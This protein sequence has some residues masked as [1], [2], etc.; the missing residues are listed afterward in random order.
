MTYAPLTDQLINSI[1][2]IDSPYEKPKNSDIHIKSDKLLPDA[3][4]E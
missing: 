1:I 3:A 4:A 2:G